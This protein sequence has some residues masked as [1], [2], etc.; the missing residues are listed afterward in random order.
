MQYADADCSLGKTSETLM[1]FAGKMHH[2]PLW[3]LCSIRMCDTI[4]MH[5]CM[6]KRKRISMLSL[7]KI[8]PRLG[9]PRSSQIFHYF[10]RQYGSA[11][12]GLLIHTLHLRSISS[13]CMPCLFSS[14][15]TLTSHPLHAQLR[16]H[17]HRHRHQSSTH[18]R[19]S[20]HCTWRKAQAR[21]PRVEPRS[22]TMLPVTTQT[23]KALS[24]W[25]EPTLLP[26]PRSLQARIQARV[27]VRAWWGRLAAQGRS[28]HMR[29]AHRWFSSI[30]SS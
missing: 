27:G 30:P 29:K 5:T 28:L 16:R 4:F 20:A 13:L 2:A 3:N 24:A 17:H 21:T 6:C 15:Y 19:P 1:R 14:T 11:C 8:S 23:R 18:R 26:W 9:Y 12:C 25:R 10:Q 22:L 7:S